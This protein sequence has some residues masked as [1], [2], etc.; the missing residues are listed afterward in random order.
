MYFWHRIAVVTLL[1]VPGC[2]WVPKSQLTAC[3]S[4]QRT[5]AEQ[6]RAQLAE[7]A[8]LKVHA[9]RI[10]NQL[11][12]SEQ[13]LAIADEA[14]KNDRQQL[15]RYKTERGKLSSDLV[16]MARRPASKISE[17]TLDFARRHPSLRYDSESG[18]SKLATDILFDS[19]QVELKSGAKRHLTDFAAM[20]Q[21]PQ[22]RELK[23]MIAGHTDNRQ[24]KGRNTRDQYPTNWHLSTARAIAVA[25]YLKDL[26]LDGRR[27]GIAGFGHHQPIVPNDDR[28][29]RQQNR[30]VELFVVS[31]DVPVVGMTE[32]LTELY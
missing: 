20:M 24:I 28:S 30:R 9:R 3:Q 29:L 2:S 32:T 11:I 15:D 16:G 8:N 10:E 27:M 21:S 31:P 6:S 23:I 4:Q 17:R 13:Q 19:G 5:L 1:L 14:Y 26:G 18:I 25:D 12:D 22:G 7:I